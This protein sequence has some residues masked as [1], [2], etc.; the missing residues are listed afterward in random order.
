MKNVKYQLTVVF[1]LLTI[2]SLVTEGDFNYFSCQSERKGK[3]IFIINALVLIF[4]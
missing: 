1:A 2:A 3:E 4:E